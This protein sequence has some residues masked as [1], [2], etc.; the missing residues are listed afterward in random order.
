MRLNELEFYFPLRPLSPEKLKDLFVRSGKI[1]MSPEFPERIGSLRFQPCRGFMKGYIDLVFR[2]NGRFYLVDWKSNRLGGRVADYGGEAL[3][4]TMT[5]HFYVL[6]Y[7]LYTLALHRYLTLRVLDYDYG[8]HFGGVFYIFL[9]GV[10]ATDGEHG[11]YRARPEKE[12][13]EV[14]EDALLDV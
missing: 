14:M 5:D 4:R 12:F 1:N 9:R 6:Q 8:R 10:S 11:I 2:W 3:D 13:V 7:H